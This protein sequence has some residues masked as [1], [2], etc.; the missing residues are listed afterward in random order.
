MPWNDPGRVHADLRA[1]YAALTA[2]RREQPSPTGGV[3]WLHARG[4]AL[5]FVRE[6]AQ[7]AVLVV[8]A[9]AEAE[10]ELAPG[11]LTA[12]QLAA[13][14]GEPAYATATLTV[15]LSPTTG[16]SL[17]PSGGQIRADEAVQTALICTRGAAAA[18][19]VLPGTRLPV[20]Q[21]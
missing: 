6:T 14:A 1:D 12:A 3:R 20:P 5:P 18:A 9:R 10:V 4:D 8:V 17:E 11:T 16:P 21:P 19:W 13:L 2:L 7:S 15:A